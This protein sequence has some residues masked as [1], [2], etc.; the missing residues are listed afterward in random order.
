V[1][2]IIDIDGI[3]GE[4]LGRYCNDLDDLGMYQAEQGL[5]KLVACQASHYGRYPETVEE[6]KTLVERKGML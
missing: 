5:Y 2:K 3:V 4:Y 6:L 1:D